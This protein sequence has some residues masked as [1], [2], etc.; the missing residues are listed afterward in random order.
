MR[1]GV[2][3]RILVVDD[4][5]GVLAIMVRILQR[6]GYEAIGAT[7]VKEARTVPGPLAAMVVDI[8]LPNGEPQHVQDAHPGVPM[9]TV[10]GDHAKDPGL[11]KPFFSGDLVQAVQALIGGTG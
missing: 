5:P 4:D 2:A 11:R 7:R 1:P 10:S 9:L 3:E 6:A 8:G